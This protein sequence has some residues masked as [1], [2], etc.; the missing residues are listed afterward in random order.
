MRDEYSRS[1]AEVSDEASLEQVSADV[2]VDRR[3][4]VVQQVDVGTFVYGA[5]ER[6]A[7]ALT[8]ER[9]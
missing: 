6:D 7:R 9:K 8:C 1:V 3:Q 4:G 2:R 5:G